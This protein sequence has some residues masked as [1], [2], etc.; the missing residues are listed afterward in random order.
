MNTLP[1]TQE[2][3]LQEYNIIK[4]MDKINGYE[5]AKLRKQERQAPNPT[6]D[7]SNKKWTTFTYFGTQI[8]RLL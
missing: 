3:K 2:V 5:V 1:N 8:R 4:Q 7:H 6:E